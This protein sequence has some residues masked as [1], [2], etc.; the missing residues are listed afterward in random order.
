MGDA[1]RA[2]PNGQSR[3]VPPSRIA[4]H[5]SYD[6]SGEP[7]P[8]GFDLGMLRLSPPVALSER[9]RP[10]AVYVGAPL[11]IGTSLVNVGWGENQFLKAVS[12]QYKYVQ[13]L[14]QY[15]S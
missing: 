9:V 14:V 3:T 7:F 12:Y 11:P 13:L 1:D 15:K 10:A 4:V 6:R 5:P 8:T 2:C